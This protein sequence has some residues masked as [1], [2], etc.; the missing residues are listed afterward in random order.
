M[1]FPAGAERAWTRSVLAILATSSIFGACVLC[2][3][4]SSVN[5]V[6]RVRPSAMRSLARRPASIRFNVQMVLIPTTV[7]DLGDRPIMGLQKEDFHLFDD[8]VEQRIESFTVDQTPVSLGIVFDASG[9]MKNKIDQS[10]KAVDQFLKTS[11]SGDEFFVVQ[12]SDTPQLRVGFTPDADEVMRDLSMVRPQGWT[13]MLDAM[14]LAVN[15]MKSA[16]NPHKALLVLSDGSDNNS[17]YSSGEIINLL[18]ESD[19][20]VFAIGLFDR[21]RFLKKAAEETGGSMIVVHN[22]N[23]LPDA[24]EKLS[25]QLRSQYLLGYYPK[26]EVNDGKFHKVK[27]QLGQIAEK[28]KLRM[29]W[30]HGYYAP[31]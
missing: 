26:R 5:I 14:Y 18:R 31:Y 20:R 4:P 21:A 19:I 2:Q 29:A 17:R 28:L 24:V 7:T 23:E 8:S 15:R 16:K 6:P 22:L 11:I 30:R 3:E 13:A 9:S 1:L 25:L 27:V 10:F 12:F